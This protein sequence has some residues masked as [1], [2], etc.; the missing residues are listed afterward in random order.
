MAYSDGAPVD[1]AILSLPFRDPWPAECDVLD[2]KFAR[3]W[4][5]PPSELQNRALGNECTNLH[6]HVSP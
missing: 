3:S 2:L 4:D 1:D 6:I 5:R